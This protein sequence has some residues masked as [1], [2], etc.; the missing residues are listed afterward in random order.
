VDLATSPHIR[1]IVCSSATEFLAALSPTSEWFSAAEPR[2]WIFR[3][4]R[5][6]RWGLSPSA[7]RP[8]PLLLHPIVTD[9]FGEWHNSHQFEAEY[10]TI[11]RFFQAADDAG[12]RLPEDSQPVREVL[13]ELDNWCLAHP[14]QSIP[15]P[16]PQLWSLLALAQ[17][18]GVPTRF[19]DWTRDSL[20]AAYFAARGAHL[21]DSDPDIAVWAFNAKAE[22][23][24]CLAQRISE[25]VHPL[26]LITAP[27]ADNP[28]LKAQR[29]VHVIL[30]THQLD[31]H[32][33]AERKDLI[34]H[35][36][37]VQFLSDGPALLKFTVSRAETAA[38]LRLLAKH[39][40][41]AASLFPGYGGVVEAMLEEETWLERKRG[42]SY[43]WQLKQRE[44]APLG[45]E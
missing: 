34:R 21:D 42:E 5:N 43:G 10:Y 3:G 22:A 8:H 39:A 1:Q 14:H 36:T 35:L 45:A 16:P 27:Y 2:D 41:S 31:P 6:G 7:F 4:Q 25:Y 15:W 40:M 11:R 9:P 24:G 38:L 23:A 28:N 44:R 13:A 20:V 37:E 26:H 29:G 30:A 18:H 17:H 32:A 12:L 33:P 19:L